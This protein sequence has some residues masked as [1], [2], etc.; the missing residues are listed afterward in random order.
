[1]LSDLTLRTLRP[2]DVEALTGLFEANDVPDVTRWFDP[3]PLTAATAR[4][5]SHADGRDLY[6]G[7]WEGED[8]VGLAMVRGWDGGH[9]EP[10]F[11]CLVDRRRQSRGIGSA[12]SQLMCVE[13]ARRGVTEVRARVHAGNVA[14]LRMLQRAG[15]EELSREAGRVLLATTLGA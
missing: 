15:F 4:A 10:A 12:I 1:V 6:W 7:A 3:F 9:A 2:E 14:S 5:L 13:L 11:G 8:L